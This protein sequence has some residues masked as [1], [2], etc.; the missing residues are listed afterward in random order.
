MQL[1]LTLIAQE[2]GIIGKAVI[3]LHTQK[4]YFVIVFSTK[5]K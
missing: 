5:C 3:N 4:V 1:G 2:I